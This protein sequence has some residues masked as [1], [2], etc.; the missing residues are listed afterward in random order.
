M[1][2]SKL[3]EEILAQ[4]FRLLSLLRLFVFTCNINSISIMWKPLLLRVTTTHMKSQAWLNTSMTR[5]GETGTEPDCLFN[6]KRA[7]LPQM[8]GRVSKPAGA[9]CQRNYA[10]CQK[11]FP[12]AAC[13][14]TRGCCICKWFFCMHVRA[15]ICVGFLSVFMVHLLRYG[16]RV[17]FLIIS[18]LRAFAGTLSFELLTWT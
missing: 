13:A 4:C 17:K 3:A 12:H 18:W 8:S 5:S 10:R 9:C 15:S 16:I 1:T 7:F 2:E 11:Q 6:D 14:N